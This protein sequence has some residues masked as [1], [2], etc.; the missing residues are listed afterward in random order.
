MGPPSH[1]RGR[2]HIRRCPAADTVFLPPDYDARIQKNTESGTFFSRNLATFH[3]LD[4]HGRLMATYPPKSLTVDEPSFAIQAT[5]NNLKTSYEYDH[6][7]RIIQQTEAD[8]GVTEFRYNDVGQLRFTRTPV[9][10]SRDQWTEIS[11]DDLGREIETRIVARGTQEEEPSDAELNLPRSERETVAGA[12]VKTIF[13]TICDETDCP[14]PPSSKSAWPSEALIAATYPFGTVPEFGDTQDLVAQIM[15]PTSAQ[16]FVV[17]AKGRTIGTVTLTHDLAE[18]QITWVAY[19]PDDRVIASFNHNANQGYRYVY[20]AWD[21]LVAVH[22]LSPRPVRL[23]IAVQNGQNP[24]QTVK[25]GPLVDA[26]PIE[27]ESTQLARYQHT[28]HRPPGPGPF[29]Q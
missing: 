27:T 8:A 21:R 28:P 6:Y 1:P 10:A 20:D 3:K 11:Y 2:A 24:A 12:S 23:Q 22:D 4:V 26:A 5:A 15:G 7:D 17:D 29:R 16:R 13:D 18:P 25:A 19:D 9:Q 14:L